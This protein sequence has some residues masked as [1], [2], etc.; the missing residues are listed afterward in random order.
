MDENRLTDLDGPTAFPGVTRREFMEY[1]AKLAAL[2]GISS[3][4]VPELAEAVTAAAKRPSVIWLTFQACT[5]CTV[6]LAQNQSPGVASLILNTLSLDYHDTLM[7]P[8]GKA[9]EKSLDD[10]IKAG[11]YFLVVEGAIPTKITGA[12]TAGGE[13]FLDTLKRAAVGATAIISMGNCSS[14]GGIQ[15]ASPNP[16]GAKGVLDAIGKPTLNI[17]T[18]PGNGD[19]LVAAIAYVL[20]YG[21]VPDLDANGRPKFLYGETIHDNCERRGHFENGEFVTSFNDPNESADFC[22]FKMGCKGPVTYAPC[23]KWKWNDR[24]NFCIGS[25]ICTGCAEPGFWDSMTPFYERSPHFTAPGVSGVSVD[26]IGEVVGGVAA[27]GLLGHLVGQTVTGRLGKGGPSEH[28]G[29]VK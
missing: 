15:A 24:Q 17:S 8:A 18:C 12:G 27:V 16:T 28:E 10:A 9:A 13:T 1:T 6:S 5:G 3:T 22:L 23:A 14:F 29:E 21:K 7:A 26:T 2:I 20:F 11:K 4:A 19:M 25:G